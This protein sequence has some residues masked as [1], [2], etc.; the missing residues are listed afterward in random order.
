[1]PI[2]M[3][4]QGVKGPVTG[5]YKEWIELESCQFGTHRNIRSPT[6]G[7]VNRE[8]SAQS[9]SEIV[10]TKEQDSSSS[11][12]FRES[13]VGAAKKV[14]IDFLKTDEKGGQTSFLRVELENAMISSYNLSGHGGGSSDRPMESLSLNFT[15][16]TFKQT[17]HFEPLAW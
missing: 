10:V 13:L 4:Y 16:S 11:D 1:M 12:L 9:L 2:Y 5:Q 14:A 3:K 8:A 17:V 6:G 15:K 7:G